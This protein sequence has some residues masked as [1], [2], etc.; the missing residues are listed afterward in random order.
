MFK[1]KI[2]KSIS[3][4]TSL[5]I[6]NHGNLKFNHLDLANQACSNFVQIFEIIFFLGALNDLKCKKEFHASIMYISYIG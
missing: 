3:K 5:I 6:E 4:Q 1:K 2:N